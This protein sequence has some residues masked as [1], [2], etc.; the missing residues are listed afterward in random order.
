VIG[1]QHIKH[2]LD[3]I[4]LSKMRVLGTCQTLDKEYLR[5][6]APPKPELVRP[7]EVLLQHMKSVK[8][9]YKDETVEYIWVCSQLKAVRQ[10][11]T[12]QHIENGFAIDVYETHARI[13]LENTDLNE[14]NQV[15]QNP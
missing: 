14:Y 7:E 13:A 10:D 9:K 5:L 11:L 12:I 6:T 2:I 4:D 1:G 3:E 15:S 8:K